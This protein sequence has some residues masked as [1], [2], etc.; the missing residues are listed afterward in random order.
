MPSL[1]LTRRAINELPHPKGGQVYYRDT[2][3]PGFGLRIGTRSKMFFVEG[4]VHGRT[5]RVTIG[6]ADVFAPEIA[7]KRAL[8]L[9]SEM[10]EGND[11]NEQKRKERADRVT[12]AAAFERFFEAR[13]NLSPH[14]VSSYRRTARLY[15]K[16][17]SKTAHG[18]DYAPDGVEEASSTCQGAWRNNRKQRDAASALGLQLYCCYRR[19]VSSKPGTNLVASACMVSRAAAA[20]LG[21]S[22][23]PSRLVE[24]RGGG[25]RVFSGLPVSGFVH[26]DAPGRVVKAALGER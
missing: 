1:R 22:N 23:G 20:N 18:R 3:L 24:S 9:L 15:L 19:K 7:R 4:Q 25:T 16:A 10:A 12:M 26:W 14:T 11:P 21:C 8:S 13:N 2:A 5:R 17:W 6:R